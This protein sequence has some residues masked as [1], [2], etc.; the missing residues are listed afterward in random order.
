YEYPFILRY[1]VPETGLERYYH[2]SIDTHFGDVVADD[3]PDLSE[4]DLARLLADPVDRTLWEELLPPERFTWRGFGIATADDVT[5]PQAVSAVKD[6]L[7]QKGAMVTP[8]SIAL[9]QR[10]LR[11]LVGAP[12]L[13]FGLICL[14]QGR[15]E[16]E[17]IQCA[18]PTVRPVGRS[19]LLSDGDVSTVTCAVEDSVYGRALMQECGTEVVSDLTKLP[20][21]TGY[22]WHLMNQ[23]YRSLAVAAL[24]VGD[25]PV[26]L[27]ELASPTPGALNAFNTMRLDDVAVQFATALR[28]SLDEREDH[29]QAV[30]KSQCT[31][32]H[33]VVEW[34]F[35]EAA[36]K[37]LEAPAAERPRQMEDIVFSDVIPLYGLSDIRSSSSFRNAAIAADLTEQL[38]LAL[39]VVVEAS[40]R[41]ALPVLDELGYRIERAVADVEGGLRAEHE[42]GVQAFLRR[43]VEGLFDYLEG[44]GPAVADRISAYRAALDPGLGGVY[45]DRKRYEDSVTRIN[46]TIS[47]YLEARE[48]EAQRLVPH[49]FEKY[50]TDGV[51]H[52]IY[53]GANLLERDRELSP[54][55]L[56]NLRLWQLMTLCGTQWALD[57]LGPE[58]PMRLEATHLALVHNAPLTIRFRYDEKR[59]DVD[60]AYNT[61]YEIV[62]KR[63][64]KATV[65]GSNGERLTQPDHLAVVFSDP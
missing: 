61:R 16:R 44:F 18:M 47:A 43:D 58:L 30:I 10:H 3:L 50:K 39:A 27:L 32:I 59:F 36:T 6:A 31:A 45:R 64:D 14:E 33:P 11:A 5:G 40:A 9:L 41:K 42:G 15:M 55:A 8:A 21:P 62:K 35:R 65:R 23:G 26:G 29:I 38:S 24:R 4:N 60:G 57:R 52:N 2:L 25:Q 46:D 51:E 56:R 28:R 34:R 20:K 48:A 7:L 54:M 13:E 1:T 49:Y 17:D 12:D 19:L 22:D 63:I 53:V 37:Y